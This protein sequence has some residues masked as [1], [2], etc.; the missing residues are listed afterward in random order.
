LT[1]P[2]AAPARAGDVEVRDYTITVDGKKAGD[3]RLT[4]NRQDDGTVS[5]SASSEVCVKVLLVTAYS[6]SYR[7]LEV[8]KAGRLLHFES[9]GKENSKPFVVSADVANGVLQVKANGQAHTA[10]PEAWTSSC[11]Q[12]PEARFRNSAVPLLGCDSGQVSS[13]SLQYVG[14]QQLELAGQEQTCAHYRLQRDVPHDLWYDSR[15]RLVRQEWVSNGHRT[16]VELSRV[17]R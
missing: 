6:Y 1:L 10:Q 11:W 15:E 3:Y 4:I 5:V 2:V 8:W 12:L 7:G 16:V 13:A 14:A 9:S 17:S